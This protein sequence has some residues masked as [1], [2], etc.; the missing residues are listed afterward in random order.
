[1][2]GR[3]IAQRFTPAASMALAAAVPVDAPE[4]EPFPSG[5][6]P[7]QAEITHYFAGQYATARC[8][9][10]PPERTTGIATDQLVPLTAGRG[11]E[12]AIH[13]QRESPVGSGWGVVGLRR[14]FW[15]PD[16]GAVLLADGSGTAVP[17]RADLI[18][19]IAGN[20]EPGASGDGGTATGAQLSHPAGLAIAPDGALYVAESGGHR[21]RRIDPHGIIATYAGTG[22]PGYTGDGGSATAAQLNGATDLAVDA[23]GNLYIADDGNHVVRRVD[24]SGV[25][26]TVAG[27]GSAGYSGDGGPATA[28]Q[29]TRPSEVDVDPHGNIYIADPGA[30]VIRR[31]DPSGIILTIAGNGTAGS[32]G[33]TGLAT[34]ARLNV[35]E[36]VA[37][38]SLGYV[39]I[40]DTL[41]HRIRRINPAGIID[42]L[43]GDG[44]AGYNG[45]GVAGTSAQLNGPVALALDSAGQIYFTEN[46]GQRLRRLGL[47][48]IVT[49]IAGQTFAGGDSLF[50]DHGN[51]GP[52]TQARFDGPS[53]V[54]FAPGG[55]IYIAD[56]KHHRIRRIGRDVLHH[57]LD[58]GILLT[59][60]ADGTATLSDATAR[61]TLDFDAAGRQTARTDRDGRMTKYSYDDQRL[62]S[63][64]D[65]LGQ[66]TLLTY[67][68]DFRLQSITDPQ[69]RTTQLD[70]DDHGNLTSLT[71]PD[72]SRW[73]FTYD[74][75]HRMVMKTDPQGETTHY[76]FTPSGAVT[77]VA[78]PT[79]ETWQLETVH[80]DG[81][82]TADAG[83]ESDPLPAP[84]AATTTAFTDGEGGKW[85]YAFD[86]R[87]F[88]TRTTDPLDRVTTI[89]R[90]AQSRPVK[91]LSPEGRPTHFQYDAM[92]RLTDYTRGGG[93]EAWDVDVAY[94]AQGNVAELETQGIGRRYT[95]DE[96][97]RILSAVDDNNA[98]TTYAYDVAGLVRTVT[99]PLGTTTTLD[100]D[101][102]GRVVAV[103]DSLGTVATYAYDAAGNPTHIT[104][105]N[106]ESTQFA[107][108][109]M[110]R[111]SQLV[112]AN[113]GVTDLGY[114]VAG[115]G[116]SPAERVT[117]WSDPLGN[118]W[119]YTYDALGQ[120][121]AWTDPQGATETRAYD[122]N[123]QLQRIATRTGATI[124]F[125][126]DAAGQLVTRSA[127][128]ET[129][130]FTYDADG[131]L[132]S[133][134]TVDRTY[135]Y[136]YDLAGRPAISQSGTGPDLTL[137]YH[138]WH[139]QES[140]RITGL[141]HKIERIFDFAGRW[142][143]VSTD[144]YDGS[145]SLSYDQGGRWTSR[146][147]TAYDSQA[148]AYDPR[149]RVAQ[150]TFNGPHGQ[151]LLQYGYDAVGNIVA[152]TDVATT[153]AFSYDPLDQ[154]LSAT[155]PAE[156]YTYDVAG[157]RLTGPDD[158]QYWYLAPNRILATLRDAVT[159]SYTTDAAGRLTEQ[160]RD[161]LT[162][163]YTWDAFDQ[164]RRVQS[165]DA[166]VD[167]NYDAFGRRIERQQTVVGVTTTERYV[168]DG[169]QRI[170]DYDGENNLIAQ[171]FFGPGIDQPLFEIRDDVVR[172]YYVD[173]QGNVIQVAGKTTADLATY[174]YD[175]F[176]RPLAAT[177]P[178]AEQPPFRFTG[179]EWDAATGLYY[180]RARY[181][182][183]SL[184][185]FLTEDPLGL[186]SGDANLYRYVG[187]NPV[188]WR[189]P[190]GTDIWIEGPNSYEPYRHQSISVGD[191]NGTY[192]SYSFGM[193]GRWLLQGEVYRDTKPG[194]II[195]AFK[196][197]T[198]FQDVTFNAQ[199][200]SEVG[201][202]GIYGI[203]DI[204]R[205]YSQHNFERAPGVIGA[206]PIRTTP[207]ITEPSFFFTS[208]TRAPSTSGTWTSR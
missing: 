4:G 85:A 90:D 181:Y 104:N 95:Y 120:L 78:F 67:D 187:N 42:T 96:Q 146:W 141:P 84:P 153:R 176:G 163:T 137:D 197:T 149:G 116:C 203:T 177:G 49:T 59:R 76:T 128:G 192:S 145:A 79:D 73:Q 34:A 206:P 46:G 25:I 148:L 100:R 106:G 44:T 30:H 123:R 69:Q 151:H 31:V 199:L 160:I 83:T 159:N 157:N 23:D 183:P 190:N 152:R 126:Y 64:T 172:H 18:E 132:L 111:L 41:N 36:D 207:V 142:T 3:M 14:L 109:A 140:S 53:G 169:V 180:Y 62:S 52:A 168:Y 136:T 87:G 8:F 208:S 178:T 121:T 65:P 24:R 195:E 147:S 11:G 88:V 38:D 161:G 156:A 201:N 68:A 58:P 54:A 15:S 61:E 114:E 92:G 66:I 75:D 94:D 193:N 108:D 196:R 205:S 6:Y 117:H 115:C 164:L 33:D 60:H 124:E 135:T 35:P 99:D 175:S 107:Y 71:L 98:T 118:T 166:V 57:P 198:P 184:G 91:I 188:N 167:F 82:V 143:R 9:G 50:G 19:T 139:S 204:C 125:G 43:V 194:G 20:G 202:T 134:A 70:H 122:W 93:N 174:Q 89:T 86:R 112:D 56:S 133:A 119:R 13:N 10:C 37:V 113:G 51:G 77:S 55:T 185:R 7:Y 162:T 45:E 110:N 171:Y 165:G 27:T 2:A 150:I 28:A 200:S 74:T 130:S 101:A 16:G 72:G 182:D 97:R 17:L 47:D 32:S 144:L 105:A 129:A 191:P 173:G 40:A 131:L 63:M 81:S 170:A 102:Q 48:E 39:Y 158:T 1:M 80:Y 29:L 5:L 138:W 127:D 154:L 12:L 103:T 186:A 21:V 26:T 155:N 22:I 179:R 189:D